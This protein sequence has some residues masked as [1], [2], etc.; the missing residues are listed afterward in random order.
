[1]GTLLS[2]GL[3]TERLWQGLEIRLIQTGLGNLLTARE[4]VVFVAPFPT[5]KIKKTPKLIFLLV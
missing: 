4:N 1:M 2:K 5:A 3:T